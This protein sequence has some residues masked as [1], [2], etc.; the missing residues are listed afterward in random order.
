[1]S[2]FPFPD[3][4]E[5]AFLLHQSLTRHFLCRA[6]LPVVNV[7][8]GALH[9]PRHLSHVALLVDGHVVRARRSGGSLDFTGFLAAA[10]LGLELELDGIVGFSGRVDCRLSSIGLERSKIGD[11]RLSGLFFEGVYKLV[12]RVSAKNRGWTLYR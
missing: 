6:L 8:I 10:A 2:G 11:T 7:R 4:L 1:M 9:G 3:V 5:C 12:S